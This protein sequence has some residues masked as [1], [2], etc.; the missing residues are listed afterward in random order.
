VEIT[1]FGL[2]WEALDED[3]SV[4]GDLLPV[5]PSFMTKV[6]GVGIGRGRVRQ[7]CQRVGWVKFTVDRSV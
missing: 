5:R 3:V 1:P 7:V 2:L 4:A 6:L